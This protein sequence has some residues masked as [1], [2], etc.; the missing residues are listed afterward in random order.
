MK[1]K[2]LEQKEQVRKFLRELFELRSP[3]VPEITEE[4]FEEQVENWF[5]LQQTLKKN[6]LKYP[7]TYK[8]TFP[9]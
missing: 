8:S 4:M 9:Q 5:D 2:Q 7:D 3:N 1:N 6:H